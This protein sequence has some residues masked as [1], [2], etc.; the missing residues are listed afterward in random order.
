[1]GAGLVL[2]KALLHTADSDPAC[3]A[4]AEISR[5]KPVDVR[6]RRQVRETCETA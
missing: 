2:F 1:M 4:R 5:E 6:V 3:P